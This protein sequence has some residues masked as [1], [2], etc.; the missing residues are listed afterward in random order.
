M[1]KKIIASKE[2]GKTSAASGSAD[3]KTQSEMTTK[4]ILKR[5]N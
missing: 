3:S 5:K 2:N 4:L 1:A